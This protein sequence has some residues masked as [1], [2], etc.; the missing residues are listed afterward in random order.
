MQIYSIE[1]TRRLMKNLEG[2]IFLDAGHLSFA[3]F[4]FGIEDAHFSTSV[5]AGVNFKILESMPPLTMGYG[6]PLNPKSRGEV[7]R[8]FISVGG[9]L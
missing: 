2:F 6:I 4:D 7:K 3:T 9:R 5:G 8:F 1:V